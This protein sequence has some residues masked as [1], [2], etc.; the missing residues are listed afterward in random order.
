[1]VLSATSAVTVAPVII[2]TL[3]YPL[4]GFSDIDLVPDVLALVELNEIDEPL[5]GNSNEQNRLGVRD[6]PRFLDDPFW[7]HPHQDVDWLTRIGEDL[8]DVR[9]EK[10]EAE[11]FVPGYALI[12]RIDRIR[13]TPKFL[14]SFERD[15]AIARRTTAIAALEL[16]P[17]VLEPGS[18]RLCE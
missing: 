12:D 13:V 5:L 8:D 1:M 4:L 9:A 18:R 6:E 11:N 15:A 14:P 16:Q 7:V 17:H 3:R 10:I 2:A